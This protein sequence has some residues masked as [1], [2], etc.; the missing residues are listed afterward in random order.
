ME[1]WS[2]RRS[3]VGVAPDRSATAG[4]DDDLASRADKDGTSLA[5]GPPDREYCMTSPTGQRQGRS[6]K[7]EDAEGS[8]RVYVPCWEST[9]EPTGA[10]GSTK[11][12]FGGGSA[13]VESLPMLPM[14]VESRAWS[15]GRGGRGTSVLRN[16]T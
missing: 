16:V 5:T 6:V 15:R 13:P 7:G 14:T 8:Q 4:G 9:T 11:M 3:G 1:P 2:G 12:Y 10:D